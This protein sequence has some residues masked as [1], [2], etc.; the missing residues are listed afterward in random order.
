M[1]TIEDYADFVIQTRPEIRKGCAWDI[2]LLFSLETLT[3]HK[4]KEIYLEKPRV[5]RE[6]GAYLCLKVRSKLIQKEIGF[7]KVGE[8][9]HDKQY[10]EPN[11][12]TGSAT[13]K[14]KFMQRPRAVFH[15]HADVMVLVVSLRSCMTNEVLM[16]AEHELIFRGGTGS[17]HSAER[18][19]AALPFP[20]SSSYHADT[21]SS[22][23]AS[24]S[25]SSV[26]HGNPY[27]SSSSSHHA[28]AHKQASASGHHH[29]QHAAAAMVAHLPA[30]SPSFAKPTAEHIALSE[31]V[32][33]AHPHAAKRCVAAKRV[34]SSHLAPSQPPRPLEEIGL[35]PNNYFLPPTGSFM[36]DPLSG[37]APDAASPLMEVQ[38]LT[39]EVLQ[40]F[41][42]DLRDQCN[43][44]TLA[45]ADQHSAHHHA[46]DSLGFGNSGSPHFAEEGP[47]AND[48]DDALE[49]EAWAKSS[50]FDTSLFTPNEPSSLDTTSNHSL[51]HHSYAPNLAV[52]NGLY[53]PEISFPPAPL[54]TPHPAIPQHIIDQHT[55]KQSSTV[56]SPSGTS[57][58]STEEMMAPRTETRFFLLCLHR[59]SIDTYRSNFSSFTCR[60]PSS[61]EFKQIYLS[62]VPSE[63]KRGRKGEKHATGKLRPP[64]FLFRTR[65]LTPDFFVFLRFSPN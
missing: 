21:A 29:A 56:N 24:E 34:A 19:K 14:V 15:R 31:A 25:S 59:A 41:Q 60:N 22:S 36:L 3:K 58:S 40:E 62:S 18:K 2:S 46:S 16:T 55:L 6:S 32:T 11:M 42:A 43:A 33:R 20:T 49:L 51:L 63:R 1:A 17:M 30:I 64:N 9:D 12:T 28:M 4:L 7:S 52:D 26:L 45:D 48:V 39:I 38:P 57:L 27:H 65:F 5:Q 8:L 10:I 47:Q 23:Y 37:V 44:E 35:G 53:G 61:R 50:G 13:L 54:S